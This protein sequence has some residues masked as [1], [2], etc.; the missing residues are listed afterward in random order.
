[1]HRLKFKSDEFQRMLTHMMTHP[2]KL[3]YTTEN[4]AEFGLWLVK[5]DGIYVMSP[6]AE[7][8]M[9][10]DGTH[11]IFAQGYDNK[12]P[13]IWDKTYAVSPDDFVEFIPLSYDMMD[14]M[15]ENGKLTIRI[16]ET[17]L[18]VRA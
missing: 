16:S 10:N 7:R 15:E 5:D 1:M 11:V 12:Q 3:P 9:D 14:R 18:E 4:T 6:S 2:R 17:E 8:D 13:D